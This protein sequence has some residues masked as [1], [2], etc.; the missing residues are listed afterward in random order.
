[1]YRLYQ[2]GSMVLPDARSEFD[3]STAEAW[4]GALA[5]PGGAVGFDPLGAAAAPLRTPYELRYSAIVSGA[6]LSALETTLAG[7]RALVGTRAVLQRK[8]L[9]TAAYQWVYARLLELKLDTRPKHSLGRWQPVEWRFQVLDEFWRHA[10]VQTNSFTLNA[11]PKSCAVVNS[12]NAPVRDLVLTITADTSDIT[13]LTVA[14][15]GVA[16]W[17]FSGTIAVGAKALVI[18]CGARTVLNNGVN[19]YGSFALTTNHK[20]N[21]WLPLPAGATTTVVVTKTGGSATSTAVFDRY[22]KYV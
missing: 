1:M 2:F 7:W 17:T 13:A 10:T 12:G 21:D 22:Y 3:G 8:A 4:N 18:S 20:S 16:E 15:T 6:S 19:A 11:S 9:G 14:I 5:L